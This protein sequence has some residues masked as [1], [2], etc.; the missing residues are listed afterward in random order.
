MIELQNIKFIQTQSYYYYLEYSVRVDAEGVFSPM[1]FANITSIK[2]QDA[3][4]IRVCCL[5]PR[6]VCKRITTTD[7]REGPRERVT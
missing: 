3:V 5:W 7:N 6:P 4:I 1:K 2:I